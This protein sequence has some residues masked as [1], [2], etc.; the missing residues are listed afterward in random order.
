MSAYLLQIFGL[1]IGMTAC[2]VYACREGRG[3]IYR[4]YT[5]CYLVSVLLSP[6]P[7]KILGKF[8]YLLVCILFQ[9]HMHICMSEL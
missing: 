3:E 2:I 6:Y 7:I 4:E 5:E 1:D 8:V 9:P